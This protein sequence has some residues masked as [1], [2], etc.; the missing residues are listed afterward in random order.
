MSG[1]LPIAADWYF[2]N[3]TKDSRRR[4]AA[5]FREEP[6]RGV[7]RARQRRR[8]NPRITSKMTAPMTALMIAL[9]MPPPI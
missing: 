3:A 1:R 8:I 6:K 5:P 7:K 4:T 2:C 9:M